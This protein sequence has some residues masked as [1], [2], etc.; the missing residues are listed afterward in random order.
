V[1][2]SYCKTFRNFPILVFLQE[3]LADTGTSS[4]NWEIAQTPVSRAAAPLP[5]TCTTDKSLSFSKKS[6]KQQEN[7]TAAALPSKA[8]ITARASASHSSRSRKVSAKKKKSVVSPKRTRSSRSSNGIDDIPPTTKWEIPRTPPTGRRKSSSIRG[9]CDEQSNPS[10]SHNVVAARDQ[11]DESGKNPPCCE[12]PKTSPARRAILSK[13]D[14]SH[15]LPKHEHVNVL[16][17]EGNQEKVI[18]IPATS[19]WEIPRTP[20]QTIA[21]AVHSGAYEP[22]SYGSTNQQHQPPSAAEP[23]LATSPS[24]PQLQHVPFS[25]RSPPFEL[26]ENIVEAMTAKI[27]SPLIGLLRESLQS[28]LDRSYFNDP[29]LPPHSLAARDV[30]VI[31]SNTLPP[32][33]CKEIPRTSAEM[34]HYEKVQLSPSKGPSRTPSRLKVPA[35]PLSVINST[36]LKL[37]V[38]SHKNQVSSP[39]G[40][41]N[42]EEECL[43][44]ANPATVSMNKEAFGAN[45]GMSLD[46][47]EIPYLIKRSL[48]I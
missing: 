31:S 10:P 17:A 3:D 28:D 25:K 44:D 42:A 38:G 29:G 39:E 27:S 4:T 14:V 33:T 40:T 37:N 2:G 18:E 32:F 9:G 30:S 48:F 12:V 36:K 8:K 46:H 6:K 26:A 45:T 11:Q 19:H 24:N 13:H 23:S 1:G 16:A 7:S 22:C 34:V 35:H 15:N 21:T 47:V 20:I 43:S 5:T 41:P